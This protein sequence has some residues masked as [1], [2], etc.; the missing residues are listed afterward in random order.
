MGVD[1]EGENRVTKKF[2]ASIPNTLMDLG[3]K[4]VMEVDHKVR[5]LVK[6]KPAGKKKKEPAINYTL[7][8]TCFLD[9]EQNPTCGFLALKAPL[10]PVWFHPSLPTFEGENW[11]LGREIGLSKVTGVNPSNPVRRKGDL[12]LVILFCS[13]LICIV[14]QS[15]LPWHQHC[16]S[17]PTGMAK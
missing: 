3:R 11:A 17:F 14:D 10:Q 13:G 9:L 12:I 6:P 16:K 7:G 8:H 5:V 15:H 1:V 4:D 2:P